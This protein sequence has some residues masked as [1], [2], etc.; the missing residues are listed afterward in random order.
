MSITVAILVSLG[1]GA[2]IFWVKRLLGGPL[3]DDDNDITSF[4]SG[5]GRSHDS[6][7]S[8]SDD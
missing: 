8:S 2:A 4:F 3:M 6:D 5:S 1:I 7:D